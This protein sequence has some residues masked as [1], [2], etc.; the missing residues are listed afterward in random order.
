[1]GCKETRYTYRTTTTSTITPPKQL[2]ICRIGAM[3]ATNNT[4]SVAAF[5]DGPR[6]PDLRALYEYWDKARNG[7]AMP[8]RSDID[9]TQIPKLLPHLFMYDVVSGGGY[10]IRLIG[11]ELRHFMGS[12][13]VGQPAGSTMTPRGAEMI[14]KILD[15]V[16]AERVPK[17]RAGKAYWQADRTYRDFEGCFLP[18]SADGDTV[19][20]VLGGVKFQS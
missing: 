20:I 4:A 8:Q 19:N 17:F 11:E 13:A 18:L 12:K 5:I 15:A 7:R 6:N 3:T 14:V 9:P 2:R 1:M 16:V 10:K